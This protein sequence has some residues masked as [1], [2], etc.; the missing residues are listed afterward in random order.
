MVEEVIQLQV[1]ALTMH[2]EISFCKMPVQ[3]LHLRWKHFYFNYSA[4][5]VIYWLFIYS[6]LSMLQTYSFQ[7]LAFIC[8]STTTC[9]QE[10]LSTF[11]DFVYLY[12]KRWGSNSEYP[13]FLASAL[14]I[15]YIYFIFLF[16]NY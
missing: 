4:Y 6:S 3:I 2:R 14:P 16:C 7:L 9:Q 1:L 8:P 12:L 13:S 10:Y 5:I 15:S 11:N